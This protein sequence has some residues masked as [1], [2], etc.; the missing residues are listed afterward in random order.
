MTGDS[1][2]CP[3]CGVVFK[4][5]DMTQRYRAPSHWAKR[6][7]CSNRCRFIGQARRHADTTD[8]R[9]QPGERLI[10]SFCS[11]VA[12]CGCA[13]HTHK[14]T[15]LDC[16]SIARDDVAGIDRCLACGARWKAREYR[17]QPL[18]LMEAA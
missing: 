5:A 18:R 4:R 6:T 15:A 12:G 1:K 10:K 16:T 3:V 9:L 13:T 8:E 14:S 2:T 11:D 7:V 17:S